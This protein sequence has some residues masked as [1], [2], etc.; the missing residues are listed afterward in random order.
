MSNSSIAGLYK[1]SQSSGDW[2]D[3][4]IKLDLGLDGS[5]NFKETSS[6]D[7]GDFKMNNQKRSIESRC[8]WCIQFHWSHVTRAH[9]NACTDHGSSKEMWGTWTL[10]GDKITMVVT[11]V[12]M[13]HKHPDYAAVPESQALRLHDRH[14]WPLL[15]TEKVWL[16]L[17]LRQGNGMQRNAHVQGFI[18]VEIF[19]EWC[20]LSW[21]NCFRWFWQFRVHYLKLNAERNMHIL[22]D[23]GS[24]GTIL[25]SQFYENEEKE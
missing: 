25:I 12:N 8:Y 19:C 22:H 18:P 3:L 7:R 13:K 20:A 14:V 9:T 16:E 1:F 4:D 5:C 15:Y 24:S 11:K 21:A 17:R 2:C 6:S 23:D 10:E